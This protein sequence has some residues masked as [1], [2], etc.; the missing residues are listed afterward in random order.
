M[1]RK[2]RTPKTIVMHNFQVHCPCCEAGGDMDELGPNNVSLPSVVQKLVK[3]KE[4]GYIGQLYFECEG[5][6]WGTVK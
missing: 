4:C 3:C 5:K 1:K 2:K 6:K